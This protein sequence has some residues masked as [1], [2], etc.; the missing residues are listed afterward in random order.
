MAMIWPTQAPNMD[1]RLDTI[2]DRF[3]A[4][5]TNRGAVDLQAVEFETSN[6]L[7]HPKERTLRLHIH[8]DGDGITI[9]WHFPTSEVLWQQTKIDTS[10]R[11]IIYL[12]PKNG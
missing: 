3:G 4:I 9:E 12:V 7:E 2:F 11:W 8:A 5:Q 10:H 6:M 1:R